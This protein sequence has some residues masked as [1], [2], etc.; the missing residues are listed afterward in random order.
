MD[1]LT[2]LASQWRDRAGQLRAWAGAD[3]A[4][5]AWEAA[6]SELEA[7]VREAAGETLSLS[8]AAR[9]SGYAARTLRQM[10]A[11]GRVPNAGRKN[12]PRIRRADLPRRAP[13][14]ADTYTRR[15]AMRLVSRGR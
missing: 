7:A 8:E 9:E 15:D 4:A 5:K 1:A 11:E 12:A 13:A 14:P 10:V 6:A 3:G 2:A